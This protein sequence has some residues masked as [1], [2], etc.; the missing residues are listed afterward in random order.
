MVIIQKR[1]GQLGNQLF[2]MAHFA[3]VAIEHDDKVLYPCFEHPLEH[4]PRLNQDPRFKVR[5]S[6]DKANRRLH[7]SLKLLRAIAARSPWHEC[8]LVEGTP[9]KDIGDYDFVTKALNR[10]IACEGFGFR[11]VKSVIK[12]HRLL[13]ELFSFSE[14]I[15]KRTTDY[16]EKHNLIQ[17]ETVVG[18]HIRKSDYRTYRNGEYFYEDDAWLAWIDQAR[19]L[20]SSNTKPFRGV[21]FSDEDVSALVGSRND[22]ISG[23][24]SVYEDLLM[25]TKM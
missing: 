20:F 14:T 15:Q 4:F 23:P 2:T 8:L 18:F 22:L 11:D 10:F 19:S 7:R 16:I 21:I 6:S 13:T 24:G 17:N 3:A 1:V 9:F 25:L 12:H 5:Q